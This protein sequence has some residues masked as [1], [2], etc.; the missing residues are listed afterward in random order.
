MT[1]ACT[2]MLLSAI[3]RAGMD[4]I[5]MAWGSAQEATALYHTLKQ[6][7]HSSMEEI[8]ML[9]LDPGALPASWGFGP[10]L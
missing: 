5:R 4:K 1:N 3:P 8:G 2:E 10:G 9:Y 6:F 7:P